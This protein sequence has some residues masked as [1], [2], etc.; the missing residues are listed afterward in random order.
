[1][2]V[3]IDFNEL[4]IRALKYII[5]AFFIAI[6]AYLLEMKLDTK[7]IL[8]L[9]LTGACVFAILDTLSPTYQNSVRQGIGI[10]SGFK[11]VKAL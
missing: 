3:S 11:L 6:V 10:A 7:E 5:E 2:D 9:S 4:L 1:M 8:V